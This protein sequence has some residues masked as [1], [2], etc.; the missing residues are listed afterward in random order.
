MKRWSVMPQRDVGE[1]HPAMSSPPPSFCQ[2]S[3]AMSSPK[4]R[5]YVA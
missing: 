1:M 4:A 2:I 3:P 5:T